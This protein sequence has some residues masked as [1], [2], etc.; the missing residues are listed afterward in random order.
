VLARRLDSPLDSVLRLTDAAGKRVAFNDDHEDRGDGLRT[1]H[2]DSLIDATLPA[3]GTYYL[4]LGDAQDQGGPEHAYRL[5]VSA[6]QPDF[7]LRVVPSRIHARPGRYTPVSIFALRKD[8][9]AGPITLGLKGAPDGLALSGGQV[10]AGQDQVR[11]TLLVPPLTSDKPIRLELEGRATTAGHQV[12]RP[13]V[14][15]DDMMQAFAY[16]HLVPAQDLQVVPVGVNRPARPAQKPR[17]NP[18]KGS[19]ARR[20]FPHPMTVLGESPVKIPAGGTVE[21]RVI[22]SGLSSNSGKVEI[23]LSDP[24]EGITIERVARID[25]GVAIVLRGDPQKVK[26]GLKGNLIA[27]A[28]LDR[29]VTDKNGKTRKNRWV[30]GALP[31]VPFEVVP[32]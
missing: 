27:N 22:G 26:T 31:A 30:M 14:P 2:A 11:V 19:A 3:T 17:K 13:A 32:P 23:E 7:A 16:K 6:P 24:P 10:P 12:V 9:F 28:I 20:T 4:H 18:S 21:V 25:R 15:A 8:G 29:M 5:R 1:H